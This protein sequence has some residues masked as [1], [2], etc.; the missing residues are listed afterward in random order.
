MVETEKGTR[1][2][3]RLVK[4]L[5]AVPSTGVSHF[6][7]LKYPVYITLVFL[8]KQEMKIETQPKTN[9]VPSKPQTSQTKPS[10]A[11]QTQPIQLL[12]FFHQISPVQRHHALPARE[13]SW[14]GSSGRNPHLQIPRTFHWKKKV[15]AQS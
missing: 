15:G 11:K 5:F 13:S 9:P 12:V 4:H 7:V 2:G 10:K 1:N 3:T 8:P 6:S 14:N